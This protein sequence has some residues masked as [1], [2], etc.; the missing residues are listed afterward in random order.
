MSSPLYTTITADLF[1]KIDLLLNTYVFNGY[2]A[3]AQAL[4]APLGTAVLLYITLLGL[5][6]TQGF[7]QLSFNAFIK[8]AIKIGLIFTFVL[9]WGVFS[10]WVVT[11]I[12]DGSTE[13]SSILLQ[14]NPLSVSDEQASDMQSL[15]Q[16]VL[17]EFTRI[18]SWIWRAGSWGHWGP[19]F[20][21]IIVWAAGFS[22]IAVALFQWLA[23]KMIMA[24]LFVTAPLF[25]SF[26]LFKPTHTFFDRW[27]GML[28][29]Q[30]FLLLLLSSVIALAMHLAHWVLADTYTEKAVGFSLV[31]FVPILLVVIVCIGLLLRV[32]SFAS[33]LGNSV[34]T[35][36]GTSL[37]ANHVSGIIAG[38]S[39]GMGGKR[40]LSPITH[41]ST[42]KAMATRKS[43]M[44]Y[45]TFSK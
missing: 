32:S 27:L 16:A 36:S 45:R 44:P 30:A 43:T 17:I 26:T 40:M 37:L 2:S 28:C 33:L 29:S 35:L 38:G 9:Q 10:D 31:G 39:I 12:S 24:M 41:V 6:I 14:A 3:L 11:F 5:A 25:I 23:A 4:Q 8:S 7:I 21:A 22:L 13:L 15:L 18:G 20:S 19:Y 1:S 42:K 34:T